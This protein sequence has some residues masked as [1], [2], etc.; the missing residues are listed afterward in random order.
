[1]RIRIYDSVQEL[2][3]DY[4]SKISENFLTME[5]LLINEAD[6]ELRDCL[7]AILET[8][9]RLTAHVYIDRDPISLGGS[10]IRIVITTSSVDGNGIVWGTG[11]E[12]GPDGGPYVVSLHVDIDL[13]KVAEEYRDE[14]KKK[15]KDYEGWKK[16]FSD[17]FDQM[18][19]ENLQKI[20][21]AQKIL[22][23]LV[24]A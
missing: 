5:Q 14:Y 18:R 4:R 16:F 6:S 22:T 3:G 2:P 7:K 24:P 9:L 12:P 8:D 21:S 23:F 11:Y 19:K 17:I 1:M 10:N 13:L 15:K 20:K